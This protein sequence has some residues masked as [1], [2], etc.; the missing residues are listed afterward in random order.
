MYILYIAHAFPTQHLQ[1]HSPVIL[2]HAT[3]ISTNEEGPFSSVTLP[4]AQLYS[5]EFLDRFH[6]AFETTLDGTQPTHKASSSDSIFRTAH[7]KN[8]SMIESS[9]GE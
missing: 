3:S 6:S 9:K 5:S 1:G 8:I 7:L 2:A 4:T